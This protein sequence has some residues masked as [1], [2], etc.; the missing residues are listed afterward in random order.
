[1]FELLLPIDST[2]MLSLYR[3]VDVM[4]HKCYLLLYPMQQARDWIKPS[5]G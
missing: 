2:K 5:H 1:M 3:I 4:K